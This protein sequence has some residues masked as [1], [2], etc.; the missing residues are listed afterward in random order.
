MRTLH[1]VDLGALEAADLRAAIVAASAL[2][3]FADKSNEPALAHVTASITDSI[4]AEQ[5]ARKAGRGKGTVR[6]S[7]DDFADEDPDDA[8]DYR[9]RAAGYLGVVRD[10]HDARD[11]VRRLFAAVMEALADPSPTERQVEL[12]RFDRLAGLVE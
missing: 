2:R 7:I 8:E 9:R 4:L 1:D 11:A 6:L 3:H 10:D 12:A 5:A